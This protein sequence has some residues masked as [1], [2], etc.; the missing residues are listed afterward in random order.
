VALLRLLQ[1]LGLNAVPLGGLFFGGWSPATALALYWCEN[2]VGGALLALRVAIHRARTRK[3][4]HY[5][6]HLGVELTGTLRVAGRAEPLDLAPRT[7]LAELVWGGTLFTAAHGVFLWLLLAGV[8]HQRP[9]PAEL[10]DGLLAMLALQ[11]AGFAF[12]LP[13]LARRPFAAL[14]AL[15]E[16]SLGR[17]ALVHLAILGGALL[18]FGRPHPE[19][20]FLVFGALKLLADVAGAL[21]LRVPPPDPER[22]PRWARR[23]GSLAPRGGEGF[24]AYWR[25]SAEQARAQAAE[26]EEPLADR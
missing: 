18:S 16:R 7:F 9:E 21:S 4:G 20:F 11:L 23:L 5:R 10:R 2:A 17:V 3:R 14:K 22:P 13:G 24:D 25:R 15:A 8:L 19:R 1:I 6:R 12:D 26:D